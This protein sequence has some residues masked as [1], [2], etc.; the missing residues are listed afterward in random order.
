M[1]FLSNCSRYSR[2]IFEAK[3]SISMF[4]DLHTWRHDAKDFMSKSLRIFR[5]IWESPGFS[6]KISIIHFQVRICSKRKVPRGVWFDFGTSFF[7]DVTLTLMFLT[8]TLQTWIQF[9]SRTRSCWFSSVVTPISWGTERLMPI[10]CYIV[11]SF[12]SRNVLSKKENFGVRASWQNV[13]FQNWHFKIWNKCLYCI[14]GLHFQ[15][16]LLTSLL[17]KLLWYKLNWTILRFPL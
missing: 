6:K 17:W 1:Y 9:N 11:A 10:V 2:L 15:L 8:K 13:S 14:Q 16:R 7:S 5:P 3:Y 12:Q 4:I